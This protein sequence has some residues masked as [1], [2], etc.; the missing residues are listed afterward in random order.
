MAA[1]FLK[2][3]AMLILM[4]HVYFFRV[5]SRNV[6]TTI[7]WPREEKKASQWGFQTQGYDKTD[8]TTNLLVENIRASI[9]MGQVTQ[10]Q[11]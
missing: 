11:I 9:M 2:F 3:E 4:P 10:K 5:F 1:C 6:V 7:K 8:I